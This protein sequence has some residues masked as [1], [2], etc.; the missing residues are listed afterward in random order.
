MI[1]SKLVALNSPCKHLRNNSKNQQCTK[2][3]EGPAEAERGRGALERFN[4]WSDRSTDTESLVNKIALLI[5]RALIMW[6]GI[7]KV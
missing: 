1:H 2:P 5:G 7:G 4:N 6:V 3:S